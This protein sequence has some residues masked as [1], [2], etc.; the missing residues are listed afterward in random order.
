MADEVLK[1]DA[2]GRHGSSA[3]TSTGE[4]LRNLRVD[5]TT[6]RLL[7]D[8]TGDVNVDATSIDTSG[9]IGKASGTN[10]DFTTAYTSGTTLTLSSLPSD[11]TAFVADDIA[12]VVQIATDGSVTATYTRDDSIMTMSGDVL[13]VSSATFAASDTFVVYTNVARPSAGQ[14]FTTATSSDRV[15]EID[16][17]SEHYAEEELIDDTNVAAATNYYPSSDGKVLGAMNLVSIQGMISGGVTTTVEATWDDAASPDW[18]DVTPAGYD[19]LTNVT[20]G[21]SFVDT[22]FALDFDQLNA[23]KIR[24]KSVTADGTNAVQYH[25]KVRYA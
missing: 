14:S 24:I 22:N 19:L 11:I 20:G 17:V 4:E 23:K 21:A 6:G 2:N 5:D 15:E 8:N 7:V 18:V 9:Y 13:T 25:W 16:P 3:I 10:A 1:I 12:T